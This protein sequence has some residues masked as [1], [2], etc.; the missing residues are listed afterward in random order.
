MARTEKETKKDDTQD[1][2]KAATFPLDDADARMQHILQMAL[3]NVEK[4]VE[5]GGKA[6]MILV[7]LDDG[8]AVA[9]VFHGVIQQGDELVIATK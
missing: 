2:L 1:T 6:Q 8:P 4:F 3:A 9:F 7:T 5:L